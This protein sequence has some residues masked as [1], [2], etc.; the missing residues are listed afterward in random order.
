MHEPHPDNPPPPPTPQPVEETAAQRRRRRRKERSR[1]WYQKHKD[2][3][4]AARIAQGVL[5]RTLSDAPNSRMRN[6]ARS[7]LSRMGISAHEV[8][9][10]NDLERRQ[11][12]TDRF[13]G[14][15]SQR[16]TSFAER[17]NG[18]GTPSFEIGDDVYVPVPLL[19]STNRKAVSTALSVLCEGKVEHADLALRVARV[20]VS[21]DQVVAARFSQIVRRP[22]APKPP[23]TR[24]QGRR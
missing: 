17:L 8:A 1:R 12:S 5:I 3:L 18:A 11:V 23:Q 9:R 24:Q 19:Q 20:R 16:L 22:K 7:E 10:L 2:A 15:L 4:K 6:Q 14:E 21:D 13:V